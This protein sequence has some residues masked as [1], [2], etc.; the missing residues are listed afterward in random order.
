MTRDE[1]SDER[2]LTLARNLLDATKQSKISWALTDVE[3]RFIYAGSRSS[4]T[5]EKFTDR[6]NGEITVLSLLNSRG[7]TVDSLETDS[8]KVSD[9]KSEPAPWNEL[10]DDLYH[11][12]RRIA[13]NV[14]EAIDSMLSDIE[15]GTLSPRFQKSAED[16]WAAPSSDE[17]PF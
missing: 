14:D 12:A 5:I 13:H 7:T 1:A 15:R 8:I 2:I 10:L 9:E 6:W 17:P 3:Q 16:P 4:V 11:A